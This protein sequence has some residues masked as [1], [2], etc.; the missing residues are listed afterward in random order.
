M[1]HE[2]TSAG[3]GGHNNL[4][5]LAENGNVYTWGSGME[6]QLGHGEAIKFLSKPTKIE[7]KQLPCVVHQ[8]Q[9]GDFYTAA[10]SGRLKN[11]STNFC[12]VC[13]IVWV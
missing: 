9:A 7:R 4:I 13:L 5:V 11:S 6:G 8:V 3:S 1:R 2:V 10:I 12:G